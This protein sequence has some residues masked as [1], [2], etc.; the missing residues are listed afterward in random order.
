M[1]A[2]L[3]GIRTE[4]LSKRLAEVTKIFAEKFPH[5][6]YEIEEV[7][8]YLCCENRLEDDFMATEIT[9]SFWIV[10]RQF[11]L[12][13]DP[14]GGTHWCDPD[15]DDPDEWIF[16]HHDFCGLEEVNAA[17]FHFVT[18]VGYGLEWEVEKRG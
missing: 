13:I 12:T 16:R 17:L 1:T 9:L 15:D 18:S 5:L 3:E 11:F 4:E 2:K 8:V 7:D 14:N 10:T 6:K